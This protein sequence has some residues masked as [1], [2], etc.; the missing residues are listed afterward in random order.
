MIITGQGVAEWVASRIE[1]KAYPP[2]KAIGV[3][4]DGQII[5][6][7]I[8]NSYDGSDIA[9]TVVGEPRAWTR[10]FLRALGRYI[11]GE[12]GCERVTIV[13]EQPKV[14]DLALRLGGRLEGRLRDKFGPGRNA[15]L[16]G[17]LKND[18]KI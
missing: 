11:F 18:W 13:T 9:A 2:Y 15:A 12:L 8:L 6:G 17:I 5:G 7:V 1:R 10:G 3:A 4:R 14:L 16:I